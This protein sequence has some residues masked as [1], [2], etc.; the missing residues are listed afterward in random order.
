MAEFLVDRPTFVVPAL[1]MR[2]QGAYPY[3]SLL[4]NCRPGG[5][6]AVLAAVVP[7]SMLVADRKAGV[8]DALARFWRPALVM[9]GSNFSSALYPVVDFALPFFVPRTGASEQVYL[10]RLHRRVDLGEIESDFASLLARSEGRQRFG[11]VLSAGLAPGAGL[12]FDQ[13]HP[14]TE[15]LR[16]AVRS[17]GDTTALGDA[18]DLPEPSILAQRAAREG[19][20]AREGDPGAV[21]VVTG[22][23][24]TREGRISP[25]DEYSKWAVLAPNRFLRPGDIL[26]R[27]TVARGDLRMPVVEVTED[28]LPLAASGTVIVLRPRA[29]L[30]ERDRVVAVHYLRSRM[31]R[32]L[33]DADRESSARLVRGQL[34]KVPIPRANDALRAAL[35]DLDDART[36]F[37]RWRVQAEEVL[38]AAF[39]E[40][41]AGEIR[42]QVVASG[43]ELRLRRE[44]ALLISDQH[45]TVR[46]RYPYPIA[47]RWRLVEAALSAE[48]HRLALDEILG[49]A[50]VLLCYLTYV[51]LA[52]TGPSGVELGSKKSLRNNLARKKGGPTFGEWRSAL[53]EIRAST[54]VKALPDDHP[55]RDL[56]RALEEGEFDERARRLNDRRNNEAHLRGVDVTELPRVVRQLS[57][58]L[59]GLLRSVAFLADLRL[60]QVTANDWNSLTKKG[61]VSFRELVGDHPVVRTLRLSYG[62]SDV[63][64]GS[65]YLLDGA[66]RLHLL[67]PYLTGRT[68][69][70]CRTWSTFH[71]DGVKNGLVTLKCLE[72][73]HT[74]QDNEIAAAFGHV[75]LL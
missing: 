69:P 50:E 73:G 53:R 43:R 71:L 8:R 55:A 11:Y 20:L 42:D 74:V 44:A 41:T 51:A 6:S 63:E 64:R 57:D 2:D 36:Q 9:Y 13:H 16:S 62:S 49:A 39:S 23:D 37:E 5:P 40:A 29:G 28:D 72:H 1:R 52:L 31:A 15:A 7:P 58:D 56:Q 26:L 18:F 59:E 14:D 33:I 21:R 25:A 17:L 68:C 60:V 35:A 75:G 66:D 65:L 67:R 4:P 47:F 32:R 61:A 3:E 30:D 34:R 45:H 19:R 48:D 24:L 54:A 10:F 70:I 22:R 38:Q 27:E 46:T 12:G